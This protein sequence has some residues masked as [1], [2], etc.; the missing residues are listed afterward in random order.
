MA[1]FFTTDTEVC[2]KVE[3][4]FS[5]YNRPEPLR[6]ALELLRD[7]YENTSSVGIVDLA[8]IWVGD[9]EYYD[10]EESLDLTLQDYV[11]R[12]L[13]DEVYRRVCG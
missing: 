13:K 8:S 6:K 5:I 7:E 11:L 10:R 1:F 12:N 2:K 3:K 4:L 9:W